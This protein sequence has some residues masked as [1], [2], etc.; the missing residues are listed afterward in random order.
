M[1]ELYYIQSVYTTS[2][3]PSCTRCFTHLYYASGIKS[4][5]TACHNSERARLW[6]AQGHAHCPCLAALAATAKMT[7]L[8]WNVSA[9]SVHHVSLAPALPLATEFSF[10]HR[11]PQPHPQHGKP[12]RDRTPPPRPSV[13]PVLNITCSRDFMLPT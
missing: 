2:A 10:Y 4:L 11:R 9:R 7:R 12:W 5:Y 1:T 3:Y 8:P 6:Q 13:Q